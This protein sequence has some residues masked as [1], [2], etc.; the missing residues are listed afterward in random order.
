M[1]MLPMSMIAVLPTRCMAGMRIGL[2]RPRIAR[3][4]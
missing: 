2:R 3:A 1:V 4:A